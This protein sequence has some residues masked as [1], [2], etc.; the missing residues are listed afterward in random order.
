MT[1]VPALLSSSTNGERTSAGTTEATGSLAAERVGPWLDEQQGSWPLAVVLGGDSNPLSFVRSLGRRGIPTL[2]VESWRSLGTYTRFG[3]VALLQ[4]LTRRPEL[5]LEFLERVGSR[6]AEPG[7][8]FPTSDRAMLLVARDQERLSRHFRFVVS[9]AGTVE[10]LVDKR[11]QYEL[12]RSE[13]VPMPRVDFPVA[14][15]DAARLA[16]EFAYPCLVKPYVSDLARSM[17]VGTPFAGKKLFVV[18]SA[19]E[20][21]DTYERILGLG[22]EVMI[23]ELVP[24]PDN[25]IFTYLGFWDG[26]GRE[27]AWVTKQKLRQNP[28]GFGDGSL[29]VTVDAPEVAG[30]SRRF[31]RSVGYRGFVAIEFKRDVRDGS[32][33]LIEVNPRTES[34]NQIAIEAGVDF[35]WIAYRHLTGAD[36][37]SEPVTKGRSGVKYVHEQWD[38]AAFRALRRTGEITFLSWLRSLSGVRAR[39]IW[40][41]DDPMPFLAWIGGS[42]MLWLGRI[43]SRLR[44]TLR[45]V[46]PDGS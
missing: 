5:W 14:V 11:A 42:P 33:R 3:E 16:D 24:G 1:L 20:L 35:P 26:A 13:G 44:R 2:M 31:L 29:Q 27:R 40:A 8:L 23:Q 22:V 30:L 46:R 34:G 32:L 15:E 28:P 17:L 6:L 21:V 39:A 45:R 43:R 9:D 41:W 12:A 38:L 36:A 7:I 18:R 10:T 4:D 19:S 25:A 37:G